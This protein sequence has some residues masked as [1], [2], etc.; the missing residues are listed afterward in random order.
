MRKNNFGMELASGLEQGIAMQ[1]PRISEA[2]LRERR[3]IESHL[4]GAEQLARLRTPCLDRL[5]SLNRAMLLDELARYR[6][7]GRFPRNYEFR[8]KLVPHFVDSHGTRCALAHL[9]EISGQAELVLDIAGRRNNARVRE[10]SGSAELLA[11]LT[12]AGLSLEEA[13][14]IQPEYCS[15]T[16]ADECFCSIGGRSE[17]KEG[18]AFDWMLSVDRPAERAVA[19]QFIA[20]LLDEGPNGE[21]AYIARRLGVMYV[22]WNGRIW[23][24]SHA[25]R[26]W[27]Q[28]RGP[29]PHTDHLHISLTWSGAMKQTSFWTG[30]PADVGGGTEERDSESTPVPVE[31]DDDEN[32]DEDD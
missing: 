32:E 14:R 27:L 30:V 16:L 31:G 18:R 1:R 15:R 2:A 29:N 25:A 13:A 11:W 26:G 12:S 9:L 22:I 19:E 7:A 4:R 10:L 21:V 24:A 6:R 20:W 28:Y 3:R 5:R 8:N 17:H 23:S